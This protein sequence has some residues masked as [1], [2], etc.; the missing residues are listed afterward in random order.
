[1]LDSGGQ[2]REPCAVRLLRLALALVVIVALLGEIGYRLLLQTEFVAAAAA[3]DPQAQ[4]VSA[5]VGYFRPLFF[6]V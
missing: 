6:I 4:S 1:M 3:K 5:S 2:I